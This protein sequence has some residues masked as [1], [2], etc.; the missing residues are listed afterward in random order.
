MRKID[1]K[2][3]KGDPWS[4]LW[5]GIAGSTVDDSGAQGAEQML[6]VYNVHLNQ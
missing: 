4:V 3:I 6:A 1:G 5:G 2:G